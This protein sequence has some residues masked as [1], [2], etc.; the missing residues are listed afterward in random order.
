MN[1]QS[2]YGE[3]CGYGSLHPSATAARKRKVNRPYVGEQCDAAPNCHSER[4]RLSQA[5]FHAFTD[6]KGLGVIPKALSVVPKAFAVVSKGLSV[7][8]KGLPW[9]QKV[10]KSCLSMAQ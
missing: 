2:G 7:T 4:S 5:Q 10:W 6:T 3:T 8:P 9:Q 1:P